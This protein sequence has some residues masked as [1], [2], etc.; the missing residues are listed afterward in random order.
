MIDESERLNQ[1]KAMKKTPEND[2]FGRRRVEKGKLE[3]P[4]SAWER[5]GGEDGRGGKL[6]SNHN[7]RKLSFLASW[8]LA[9]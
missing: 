1:E 3:S 2:Q 4:L 8:R 6:G 9:F 5:G 7:S